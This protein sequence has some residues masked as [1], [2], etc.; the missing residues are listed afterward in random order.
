M[1]ILIWA[2][3]LEPCL[4]PRSVIGIGVLTG[5]CGQDVRTSMRRTRSRS[6]ASCSCQAWYSR[7]AGVHRQQTLM[8][9]ASLAAILAVCTAQGD[10]TG[11]GGGA[12][13]ADT[14]LPACASSEARCS[15]YSLISSG[16][17]DT[18]DGCQAILEEDACRELHTVVDMV[19]CVAS[20][21]RARCATLPH[22]RFF[23][24]SAHSVFRHNS[25]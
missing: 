9:W 5:T 4:E 14:S 21:P 1:S 12:G 7:R 6:H 3:C 13:A 24:P 22:L 17:C 25:G 23:A 18:T 2:L 16:T 10:G 19:L 15:R 11:G 20:P 8:Q